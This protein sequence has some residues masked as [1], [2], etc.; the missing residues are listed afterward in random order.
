MADFITK[1]QSVT[2]R[3]AHVEEPELIKAIMDSDCVLLPSHRVHVHS[4]LFPFSL[5]KPVIGSDGWGVDE[6]IID[7]IN[8]YRVKGIYGVTSW[9][10]DLMREDYSK[11]PDTMPSVDELACRMTILADEPEKIKSLSRAAHDYVND[12]HPISRTKRMVKDVFE[13]A[14]YTK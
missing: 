10:D 1:C 9:R 4:I 2:Y 7:G 8:G 11:W 3:P 13:K 5:G 6:Y 14:V 12:V